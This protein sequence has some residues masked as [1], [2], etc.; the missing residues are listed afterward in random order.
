MRCP[1]CAISVHEG[2]SVGRLN[3]HGLLSGWLTQIM[4]YPEC[5]KDIIRI[6]AMQGNNLTSDAWMQVFPQSTSRGPI[7]S[8]VPG[9]IAEDYSQAAKVLSLSPKASAALS[10]RCLQAV[11][12]DAGYQQKDLAKQIDAVLNE[13]DSKKALPTAVHATLDAIRNFG[14]FSV[15]PITDQTTTQI[16]DVE[17]HEAE[18]CLDILDAAFDHYYVRPAEAK[19]RRA[20]LDAKLKA[21]GKPVS[22]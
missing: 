7:S 2:W 6:G 16:V 20:A 18:F 10:R 1:H 15:H 9:P 14:N 12:K 21:A 22:K 19:R 13:V 8:D 4:K 11:L 3:Y 5:G 17:E